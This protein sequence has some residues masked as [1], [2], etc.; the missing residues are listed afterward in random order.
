[1]QLVERH[2]VPTVEQGGMIQRAVALMMAWAPVAAHEYQNWEQWRILDPHARYLW[3]QQSRHPSVSLDP[4]FLNAYGGYLK[5][6]QGTYAAAEPLYQRSLAIRE[7]TLGPDHPHVAT[8]LNNLALLYSDQGKYAAAEPLYQRSL[9]I[10]E[11]ALGPDH[12]HTRLVRSNLDAL[13]TG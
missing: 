9:A 8:S 3:Q 12:P 6:A 10:C 2:Q 11:K 5:F 13:R 7:K 4:V 1:M